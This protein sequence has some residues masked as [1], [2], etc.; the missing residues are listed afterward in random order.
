MNDTRAPSAYEPSHWLLV[1]EHE[2]SWR[3]LNRLI[4]GRFKHV[5]AV[6][7]VPQTDLWI[8]Y[9]V[10]FRRT[11]ITAVPDDDNA[12][13]VIDRMT[14][15]KTVLQ[16]PVLECRPHMIGFWCVPAMKHLIGLRSGA[17]LPAGLY[18]HCIAA[19]AKIIS[20]DTRR[21]R[22]CADRGRKTRAA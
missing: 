9:D 5:W 18:R 12:Q 16:M 22:L 15:G 1:F 4:P 19:G 3:W 11:V 17:L 20:D 2:T 7:Y 13:A 8:F 6:G 21:T 10:N 14:A